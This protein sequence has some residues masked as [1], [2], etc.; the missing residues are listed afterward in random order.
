M[1]TVVLLCAAMTATPI[2]S[3]QETPFGISPNPLLLFI[4]PGIEAA[5]FKARFAINRRQGVSALLGD[6]GT[7]KST[8]VRYLYAEYDARPDTVA[9][10]VVTS[11][12]TS[13]FAMIRQITH[14]FGLPARRSVQGHLAEFYEFLVAQGEAGRNVVLFLD[15]AQKMTNGQ[16]ETVRTFLNYESNNAKLI[17]VILSGQL[18]LKGRLLSQPLR[19]LHSRIVAPSVL[20]PL[21]LDELGQMIQFRCQAAKIQNPVGKD[22]LDALYLHSQGVP[23]SALRLLSFAYEMLSLTGDAQVSRE[24]I[25]QAAEEVNL[26][27]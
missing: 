11:E 21:T 18:E 1:A 6:V 16:L 5:L 27:E 19:A 4:T 26:S 24:L 7:G 20:A 13:D 8:L 17:Q 15:E 14:D 9:L 2:I 23:R 25:D 10:M 3:E 22:A 12:F